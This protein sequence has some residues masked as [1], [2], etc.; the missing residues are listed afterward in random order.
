VAIAA[1]RAGL[2]GGLGLEHSAPSEAA[3]VV[4]EAMAADVEFTVCVG[5]WSRQMEELLKR[6]TPRG[7]KR[8]ILC[9]AD[10]PDLERAITTL[11]SAELTVFVQATCLEQASTRPLPV[12]SPAPPGSYSIGNWPWPRNPSYRMK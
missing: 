12:E 6:A 3:R 1:A 8:V 9:D 4:D 11:R 10:S 2:S 7:L 5:T